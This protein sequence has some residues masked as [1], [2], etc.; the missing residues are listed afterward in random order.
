MVV[1]ARRTGLNISETA[2]QQGFSS[3]TVSRV[4]REWSE[5]HPVSGSSLGENASLMPEVRGEWRHLNTT[6]SLSVVADHVFCFT[7]IRQVKHE[8]LSFIVNN[9]I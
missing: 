5:K 8:G 7:C 9:I 6:A 1:G 2:D 4:Y 3:I